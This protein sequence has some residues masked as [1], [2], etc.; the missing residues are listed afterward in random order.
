[1]ERSLERLKV[2]F[3]QATAA[4]ITVDW[5][6]RI[7]K[8]L[9]AETP[10]ALTASTVV[11]NALLFALAQDGRI[12]AATEFKSRDE[13]RRHDET[14]ARLVRRHPRHDRRHH[15]RP[16]GFRV[17]SAWRPPSPAT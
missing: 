16:A 4:G 12:I 7:I 9:V 8:Q 1:M 3:R 14:H 11:Q 17:S 2:C 6:D 5:M 15:E 13:R 10:T